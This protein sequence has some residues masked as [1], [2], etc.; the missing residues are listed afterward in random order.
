MNQALI[1]AEPWCETCEGHGS[2]YGRQRWWGR[3][4]QTACPDCA[5]SPVRVIHRDGILGTVE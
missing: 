3:A 4:K 2:F 5:T 1:D